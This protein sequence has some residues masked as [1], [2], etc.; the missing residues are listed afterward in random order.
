MRDWSGKRVTVVGLGRT[1]LAAARYFHRRGA[2]VMVTE[3]AA[4]PGILQNAALLRGEGIAVE[5]GGHG[6]TTLSETEC[7]VLS[8]GVPV[9]LPPLAEAASRGVPVWSELEAAWTDFTAPIAALTGTNG[10][11]TTT[12]LLDH[13]V[14]QS[15]STS[16]LCGNND[17][18][19]S[20]AL[21]RGENADWYVVEVS[22]YQ[23]ESAYT[24]RPR[25]AAVL[26]VTPDHPRHG[27]LQQYAAVKARIFQSLQPGDVAVVNQD[28]PLTSVMPTPGGVRRLTFSLRGE[29]D[30]RVAD[31]QLQFQGQPILAVE[32]LRL[33]GEHNI[34]N[35]LAAM[36]MAMA[37]QLPVAAV[38]EGLASFS[39]VR[40]RIEHIADV[41]GV[42][43]YNDSKSTNLDSLRVALQ[44]F[45]EPIVLIAGGR[46][47]ESDYST[48]TELVHGKAVAL[49]AI[50][51]DGP[52]MGAA[53]G[54]A[55]PCH[56]ASSMDEAVAIGLNCAPRGAV[57]LLSPGCASFDWYNNFEERGDDFRACVLRRAGAPVHGRD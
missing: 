16:V 45:Q 54:D 23:L 57:L 52:A 18:P 20:A 2:R 48:L 29:G 6:P 50:G 26:N 43:C 15:G 40:H 5:T 28:C 7:I 53:W 13:L 4:T 38:A 33:K 19:L 51:E 41:G 37:M 47:K 56:A 36:T 21:D 25:V 39:G 9:T 27:T 10:K 42:P 46:G 22:S 14:K 32:R 34:A 31:G 55:V 12:A 1:G 17:L 24:F 44:S 8:P 3:A 30:A 11:T 35:A 49:I